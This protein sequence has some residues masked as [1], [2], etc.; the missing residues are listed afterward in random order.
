[1]HHGTEHKHPSG[2]ELIRLVQG[3]A[4]SKDLIEMTSVAERIVARSSWDLAVADPQSGLPSADADRTE[5]VSSLFEHAQEVWVEL[6]AV[7]EFVLSFQARL[8]GTPL[9]LA[10][11]SAAGAR[12]AEELLVRIDHG[13]AV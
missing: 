10:A 9:D 4:S 7:R 11:E 3:L 13:L 5:R 6:D 12:R 8:G 1:M 2:S